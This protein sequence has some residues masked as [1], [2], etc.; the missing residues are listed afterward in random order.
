MEIH[1]TI[2][3]EQRGPYTIDEVRN[4]LQQ[5]EIRSSDYAWKDGLSDWIPLADLLGQKQP[6]PRTTSRNAPHAQSTISTRKGIKIEEIGEYS[7]TT[8]Q[9]DETPLYYTTLHWVVFVKYGIVYLLLGLFFVGLP[10]FPIALYAYGEAAMGFVSLVWSII[11]A[12]ICFLPAFVSYK[13][14]EFTVT[15][16]RLIVKTGFIRR[17]THEI[18]ISKIE[19]VGVDQ[20]ILGRMFD[21]GTILTSGTGGTKQKFANV[22][23]PLKLRSAIQEIQAEKEK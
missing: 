13:T 21:A 16:K 6:P 20:G 17:Q 11:W 14:S 8:L 5:G 19:S 9:K 7:R 22:S 23:T 4:M 3:G 10:I 2:N 18:F 12:A 1:L 15:D